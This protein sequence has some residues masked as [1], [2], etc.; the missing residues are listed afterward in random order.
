[1]F[2]MKPSVHPGAQGDVQSRSQVPPKLGT[3]RP[4]ADLV[5][6][7]QSHQQGAAKLLPKNLQMS[8]GTEVHLLEEGVS[9]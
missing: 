3:L 7:V 5:G 6:L 9:F 1:M 2:R 8:Q 4:G